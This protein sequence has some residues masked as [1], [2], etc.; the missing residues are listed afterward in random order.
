MAIHETDTEYGEYGPTPPDAQHEH[1]DIEP[2]IAWKFAIWLTVGMA[3]SVAIVYG[4]YS[5][6]TIREDAARSAAQVFP[7][8]AGQVKEPPTPRLQTQPFKDI[9]LVRQ[10]EQ[11]RLSTYGWVDKGAGTVHIPIEDAMRLMEERGLLTSRAGEP[12]SQGQAVTDS[13][14]GRVA[15][16]RQ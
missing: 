7:M 16:P 6:F 14:A 12:T 5:F 15:V 10:A 1:T 13:S 9:Y 4:A 2:S 8:A 3:I 11:E